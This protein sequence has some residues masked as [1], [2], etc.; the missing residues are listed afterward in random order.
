MMQKNNAEV[1]YVDL[2]VTFKINPG[3][4]VSAKKSW[5]IAEN[6]AVIFCRTKL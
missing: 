4:L 3:Q 5:L 2:F 1:I 6:D